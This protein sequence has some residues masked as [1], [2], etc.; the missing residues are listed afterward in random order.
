M[1]LNHATVDGGDLTLT[2]G[3]HY[4]VLV[5][6]DEFDQLSVALVRRISELVK[7]GATVLAPRVKNSPSL[8]DNGRLLRASGPGLKRCGD[9]TPPPMVR[10]TSVEGKIY[11]GTPLEIGS[12]G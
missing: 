1:V 5:V 3:M 10:T 7:A 2:S 12:R 6:P 11:W 9:P 4:R 8:A